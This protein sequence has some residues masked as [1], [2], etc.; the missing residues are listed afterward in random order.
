[1]N[2]LRT[3]GIAGALALVLLAV[4][5][6]APALPASAQTNDGSFGLGLILGE[7]TGVTAKLWLGGRNAFVAAAAWSF[8][9]ETAFHVHGD[10]LWHFFDRVRIEEGR[11]PLYVGIGGRIKDRNDTDVGVRFPF[12]AT[13]LFD[14]APVDVFLEVVPILDVAP[15]SEVRMNAA[16][17]V[18]YYFD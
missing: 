13:Y 12:G 11:I 16:A 5:L 8:A 17:G 7:P 1:M 6:V 3:P 14:D 9:N 4:S 2:L 15:E 10:Y 18:R